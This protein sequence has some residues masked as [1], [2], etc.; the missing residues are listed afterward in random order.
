LGK[1]KY[2]NGTQKV[3]CIHP[4]SNKSYLRLS[5]KKFH[6]SRLEC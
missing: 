6:L 3:R 2:L 5:F 4:S 1:A